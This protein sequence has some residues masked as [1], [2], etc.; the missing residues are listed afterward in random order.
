MTIYSR[1]IRIISLFIVHTFIISI[2]LSCV[3]S[4]KKG[5]AQATAENNWMTTTEVT[6]SLTIKNNDFNNNN[7]IDI[8]SAKD[9]AKLA[10]LI[11]SQIIEPDTNKTYDHLNYELT[12]NIDLYG[13]EL[14]KKYWTP[15]PHFYGTFNGNGYT[16]SNMNINYNAENLKIAKEEGKYR[17]EYRSCGLFAYVGDMWESGKEISNAVVENIKFKDCSIDSN[18]V[19]ERAI[20][21]VAGI[22]AGEIR[23]CLIES[24]CKINIK[25]IFRYNNDSN[26]HAYIGGIVG[27]T[28]SG[29][30]AGSY[31]KNCFVKENAL[32][33]NTTSLQIEISSMETKKCDMLFLAGII[34]YATTTS[35]IQVCY[36]HS[37]LNDNK[38]ANETRI[39]GI[40]G[41]FNNGTISSCYNL[42]NITGEGGTSAYIGGIVG[43]LKT[44]NSNI[45]DC[46]NR[47]EIS[48]SVINSK[49]GSV[50]TLDYKLYNDT[51]EQYLYTFSYKKS[52]NS[53]PS[54]FDFCSGLLGI[55]VGNDVILLNSTQTQASGYYVSSSNTNIVQ[56]YVGT[57]QILYPGIYYK[58]GKTYIYYYADNYNANLLSNHITHTGY[59]SAS[60]SST[61]NYYGQYCF[62]GGMVGLAENQPYVTNCYN[63]GNIVNN[64]S[65][66]M[67]EKLYFKVLQASDIQFIQNSTYEKAM[68]N[69]GTVDLLVEHLL[70]YSV[71]TFGEVF[72]F[73]IDGVN[74]L[75]NFHLNN[76]TKPTFNTSANFKFTQNYYYQGKKINSNDMIINNIGD[77]SPEKE[78]GLWWEK[79]FKKQIVGIC[80]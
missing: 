59:Y 79:I 7:I 65:L 53:N 39:G 35:Y 33:F 22:S 5:L 77:S 6:P 46:F 74:A 42:G 4:L 16:I 45:K 75:N 3:L 48:G 41:G 50:K 55:D 18:C 26:Y 40:V 62:T 60:K 71:P 78:D 29:S 66:T 28:R 25:K 67:Q 61:Y 47:G 31:V 76:I 10:Q 72:G 2:I 69:I 56:S 36:N 44:P 12:A 52:N 19:S 8:S 63:A 13:T 27:Y 64:C 17:W 38:V 70:Q 11:N 34:G 9:L 54:Y 21:F 23:N 73:I 49:T 30:Y 24:N 14:G 58:D 32:T 57:S 68:L 51:D 20:G 43:H 37:N 1:K 15:I 80:V